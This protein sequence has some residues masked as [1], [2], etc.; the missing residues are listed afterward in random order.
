MARERAPHPRPSVQRAE[1][2]HGVMLGVLIVVAV[3][4]TALILLLT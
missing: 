3:A 4:V 1:R 2:T